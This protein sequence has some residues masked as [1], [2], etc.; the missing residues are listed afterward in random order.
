MNEL[1][2]A[3]WLNGFTGL[4]GGGGV[5]TVV[6]GECMSSTGGEGLLTGMAALVG[7]A[8]LI[9]DVE[10]VGGDKLVSEDAVLQSNHTY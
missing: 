10:A 8:R 3:V 9:D 6:F 5:V 2:L 4:P 1:N 7:G